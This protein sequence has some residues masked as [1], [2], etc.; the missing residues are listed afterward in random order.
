ME[1]LDTYT[2]NGEFIKTASRKEA[3]EKGLWHKTTHCWIVRSDG[4]ILFQMR[5]KKLNNNPGR[6]YTTASGHVLAGETLEEALHREARE[7]AGADINTHGAT[8]IE[9][10]PF[11]VDFTKTDGTPYK[12]RAL[13]HMFLVEDNHPLAEFN[14]QE[15]E[16]E[17]IYELDI[18]DTLAFLKKE[19][20][21]LQGMAV[22]KKEGQPYTEKVNI[23][24]D[25][26]QFENQGTPYEKFGGTL[27]KALEYFN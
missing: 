13:Y 21:T 11:K 6:L 12:D 17:G 2:E 1:Y 19:T 18:K 23:S 14:F 7:E 5:S 20:P 3:H 26:F 27:E 4:K 22:F 9:K 15:E 24:L 10:G 8:L 25:Q 16:L